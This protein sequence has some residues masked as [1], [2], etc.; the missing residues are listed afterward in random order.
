MRILCHLHLIELFFG[1]KMFLALLGA[2]AIGITLGLIGS[3]GTVMTIPIL[4]FLLQRPEKLAIAESLAI[5]GSIAGMGALPYLFRGEIDW[6]SVWLF[7]VPG[8]IGACIGGCGSYFLSGGVQLTVLGVIMLVIAWI[9]LFNQSLFKRSGSE[10]EIS[11]NQSSF[12]IMLKGFLVG[13]L[14]GLVGIGGGFIIVPSLMLLFHLSISVAIGT[15]LVI[16]AM[17]AGV[18]F[19]N[20]YF[21]LKFLQLSVDWQT[22]MIISIIGMIGS[23][24]A[25][26]INRWISPIHLRKV[27]GLSLFIMGLYLL[28]FGLT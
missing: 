22:I 27:F 10:G 25:A 5:V 14:T 6:K 12:V 7:G 17:N 16:I 24:S 9:M 28:V 26:M 21:I 15:S 4:V 18:G 23:L 19:F 8:M 11:Q 20:Q 13:C 3:G 2:L 1:Y